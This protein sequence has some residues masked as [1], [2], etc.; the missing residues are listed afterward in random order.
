[1]GVTF[2]RDF[3]NMEMKEQI[4]DQFTYLNT[5]FIISHCIFKKSCPFSKATHTNMHIYI[6]I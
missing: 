3:E 6:Y 2:T 1:M 4:S 5:L